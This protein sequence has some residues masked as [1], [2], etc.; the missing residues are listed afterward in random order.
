[1]VWILCIPKGPYG[2]IWTLVLSTVSGGGIIKHKSNYRVLLFRYEACRRLNTWSP[3]TSTISENCGIL[4][5]AQR[6]KIW[7]HRWKKWVTKDQCMKAVTDPAIRH[8]LSLLVGPWKL[9]SAFLSPMMDCTLT[10]IVKLSPFFQ[11]VL[12]IRSVILADHTYG[13]Y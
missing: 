12:L 7:G 4:M 2:N 8:S 5:I 10:V 6:W 9:L 1:M 13:S 11:K 3:P